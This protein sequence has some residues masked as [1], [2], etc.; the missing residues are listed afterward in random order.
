MGQ[1]RKIRLL[2]HSPELLEI[3]IPY[4]RADPHEFLLCSDIHLDNP[5]CD[6]ELLRKHLKQAQGRGAHVLMFGDVLCLMQGKRDRRA[7]KSGIRPEH[8][9]SNYFDLVFNEAAE[10]LKPFAQTILMMSDGNHETAIITHN[11]IDPLGNLTRLMRDRYGSPVEHMRYQG[12]IW[13]SFYQAGA[14][15][16]QK[17]RRT[18]L[19]FHHGAW[20]GII[21]KGTMGG[22]RYAA[23]APDAS[24]LVN[25]HNHERSIISHPCYRLGQT[26]RQRIEQRW[27]L[28]TGT[29]KEEFQGGGGWAVERI[30]MPKSLGGIWLRVKPEAEG[31]VSISCEPASS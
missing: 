22:G 29:Y 6:R 4:Q 26:G 13:F 16:E 9:G 17:T 3:R 19:F 2:R 11:E 25:G 21:T 18:T 30:V 28:Q 5:K 24:I 12:F 7:S 15:R 14:E 10:W 20:G 8:L 23:I 1:P 31:G 27:H